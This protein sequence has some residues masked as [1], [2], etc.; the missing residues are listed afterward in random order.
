MVKNNKIKEI[1]DYLDICIDAAEEKEM[2]PSKKDSSLY[3]SIIRSTMV[4]LR[5]DFCDIIN[6]KNDYIVSDETLN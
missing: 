1:M 2:D 6:E 5:Q 3:Y 4:G